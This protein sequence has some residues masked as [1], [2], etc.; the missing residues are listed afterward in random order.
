MEAPDMETRGGVKH[1]R[2]SIMKNIDQMSV[3]SVL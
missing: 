1:E 3:R 2:K